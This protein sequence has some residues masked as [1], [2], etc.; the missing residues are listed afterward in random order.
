MTNSIT[1][2]SMIRKEIHTQELRQLG[3]EPGVRNESGLRSKGQRLPAEHRRSKHLFCRQRS[4][5]MCANRLRN[6]ARRICNQQPQCRRKRGLL[7]VAAFARPR[8]QLCC[9]RLLW[10]LHRLRRLQCLPRQHCRSP[11]CTGSDCLIS[12][13]LYGRQ[14]VDRR[15]RQSDI[16]PHVQHP[17]LR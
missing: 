1:A 8:Q 4:K 15:K 7:V 17:L 14:K 11:V 10:R 16:F 13:Q 6:S 2:H 5:N 12:G 9:K 3:Q